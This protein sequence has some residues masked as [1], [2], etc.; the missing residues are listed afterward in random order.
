MPSDRPALHL[1]NSAGLDDGAVAFP[2]VPTS[3]LTARHVEPRPHRGSAS[4]LAIGSGRFETLELPAGWTVVD[5]QQEAIAVPKSHWDEATALMV[6]DTLNALP[7]YAVEW[8]WSPVSAGEA[9]G[10]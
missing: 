2:P 4:A 7:G 3:S 8:D 10:Q 5:L 1:V 9:L 6:A